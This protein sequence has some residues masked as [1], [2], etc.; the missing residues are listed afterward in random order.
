MLR[1]VPWFSG[2]VALSC[3]AMPEGMRIWRWQPMF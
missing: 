2:G 3:P 1:V